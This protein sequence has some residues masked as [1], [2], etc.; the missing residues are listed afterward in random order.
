M[1]RRGHDHIRECGLIQFS[2][3][4][5]GNSGLRARISNRLLKKS[6]ERLDKLATNE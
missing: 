5:T 2:A 6:W 1:T 3:A 4:H